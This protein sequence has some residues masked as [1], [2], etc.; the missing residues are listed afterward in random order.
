MGGS[1]QGLLNPQNEI[2]AAVT[3]IKNNL[4]SHEDE[5]TAMSG[6]DWEATFKRS[7]REKKLVEKNEMQPANYEGK[8]E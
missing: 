1:G 2:G 6:G 7:A 8:V 4:S 3:A 5:Y